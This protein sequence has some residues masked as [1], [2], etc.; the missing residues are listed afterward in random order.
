MVVSALHIDRFLLLMKYNG[1]FLF[2]V[3]LEMQAALLHIMTNHWTSFLF[4]KDSN[5]IHKH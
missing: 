3:H 4:E 1:C 5:Q 2:P